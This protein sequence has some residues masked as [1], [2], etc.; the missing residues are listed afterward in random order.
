MEKTLPQDLKCEVCHYLSK[1]HYEEYLDAL[2]MASMGW[3]EAVLQYKYQGWIGKK[4]TN[5]FYKLGHKYVSYIRIDTSQN[6]PQAKFFNTK[7]PKLTRL[8][9]VNNPKVIKNLAKFTHLNT[10]IT[11]LWIRGDSWK[12][13]YPV[14]QLP[15]V[16]EII[17]PLVDQLTTLVLEVCTFIP[18]LTLLLQDLPNL[19]NLELMYCILDDVTD[20][21]ISDTNQNQSLPQPSTS[22]STSTSKPRTRSSSGS[23]AKSKVIPGFPD[24]VKKP[25]YSL[26]YLTMCKWF[27][28]KTQIRKIKKDNLVF[29]SSLFPNLKNLCMTGSNEEYLD[30]TI[31]NF[32]SEFIP[33]YHFFKSAQHHQSLTEIQLLNAAPDLLRQVASSCPNLKELNIGEIFGSEDEDDILKT[34][35]LIAARFPNLTRFDVGM[36]EPIIDIV[37][38]ISND[39][40]FYTESVYVVA[41][42]MDYPGGALGTLKEII[43]ENGDGN[44]D[45]FQPQQQKQKNE[46]L[47]AEAAPGIA[48]VHNDNDDYQLTVPQYMSTFKI[49]LLFGCANTLRRLNIHPPCDSLTPYILFP[50]AQFV[51]LERLEISFTTLDDVG[52]QKSRIEEYYGLD[53]KAFGKLIYFGVNS[54]ELGQNFD[55]FNE[56]V[57]IFTPSLKVFSYPLF[58]DDQD[59]E[60]KRKEFLGQ[61]QKVYPNMIFLS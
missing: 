22:K 49:P 16:V 29:D 35:R 37:P 41:E 44:I 10:T 19:R 45:E 34:F 23:K 26:V 20:I 59:E 47:A 31:P 27:A 1:G 3:Y 18:S 30:L 13:D 4:I 12:P 2:K 48:E 36:W 55:E 33:Y 57:N 56:L 43:D 11:K 17:A 21:F 38:V 39:M 28:R 25:F 53:H 5:Q 15:T 54:S 8:D 7:C 14:V 51:N 61:L 60:D 9:V 24:S 52:V 58:Y 42:L 32:K 46:K 6:I 40:P 50:I